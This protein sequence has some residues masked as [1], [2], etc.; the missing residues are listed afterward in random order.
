[1]I[2]SGRR[3]T[4]AEFR[5]AATGTGLGLVAIV[6]P[7]SLLMLGVLG[8]IGSRRDSMRQSGP[9]WP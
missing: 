5:S 2:G 6:P 7:V 3:P 9:V 4:R 1:M 8:V